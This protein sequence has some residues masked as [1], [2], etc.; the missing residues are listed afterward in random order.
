MVS[1]IVNAVAADGLATQ[2]AK[3]P[4]PCFCIENVY[5]TRKQFDIIICVYILMM[6]CLGSRIADER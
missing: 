1:C 4:E 6:R 5:K 3:A 2:E